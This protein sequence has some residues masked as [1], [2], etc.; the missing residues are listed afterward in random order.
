MSDRFL[1]PKWHKTFLGIKQQHTYWLYKVIDDIFNENDFE[2]IIEI[3]TGRGAL[4]I[5]LGLETFQ[6]ELKQFITIDIIKPE[7]VDRIFKLLNIKFLQVDHFEYKLPYE[8][9]FL[10]LDGR[11]KD[12]EF[13]YFR[14]KVKAGSIIAIHDWG[15]EFETKDLDVT[16]FESV[17]E[18]EWN[19]SPDNIMTAFWRKL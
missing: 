19:C 15:R 12:K 17:K 7:N 4:S 6:R 8:K 18:E 10:F 11:G 3:G 1:H 16:G 2:R 9:L 13:N 5:L 14:N